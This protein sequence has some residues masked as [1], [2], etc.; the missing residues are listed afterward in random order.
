MTFGIHR[1]LIRSSVPAIM[2][3]RTSLLEASAFSEIGVH[4][5]VA[6]ALSSPGARPVLIL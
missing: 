4:E 6:S 1:T 5:G 2:A 3:R